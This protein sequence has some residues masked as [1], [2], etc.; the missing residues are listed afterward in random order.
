ML[1]A[2][3]EK[4]KT[5]ERGMCKKIDRFRDIHLRRCPK[6]R[7]IGRRDFDCSYPKKDKDDQS[8]PLS[9]HGHRRPRLHRKLTIQPSCNKHKS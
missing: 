1:G 9:R 2:Y 7:D 5:K 6:P 3:Q 4:S 8:R